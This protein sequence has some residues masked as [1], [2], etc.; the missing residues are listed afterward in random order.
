[1]PCWYWQK[2]DIENSP[3]RKAGVTPENERRY[4]REGA[5][6][7]YKLGTTNLL[8]WLLMAFGNF[9]FAFFFLFCLQYN[10]F[11]YF[12]VQAMNLN[13]DTFASAA[14]FYHRVDL[15]EI[16]FDFAK[17]SKKKSPKPK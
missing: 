4:R 8:F 16:R 3:S 15:G 17:I 12:S 11:E 14:V 9:Y 2:S 5:K 10:L 13:H 1:M 6:F 7:I